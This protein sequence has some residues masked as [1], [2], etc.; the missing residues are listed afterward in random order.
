MKK[1]L[2]FQIKSEMYCVD[3]MNVVSIE[4]LSKINKIP[5]SS[6]HILGVL[7][8]RQEIIPIIDLR[9]LFY[10]SETETSR[11][12]CHVFVESKAG[13]VGFVVDSV[14]DVV[15]FKDE[16]LKK[17][18]ENPFSNKSIN[19]IDQVLKIKDKINFLIDIN[20]LYSSISELNQT[21]SNKAA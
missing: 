13:K 1:A 8:L 17:A 4:Q 19:Y 18:L 21:N 20:Q 2:T 9:K 5:L 14:C 6:P 16:E 10:L 3:V 7:N 12:S 15:E 11:D